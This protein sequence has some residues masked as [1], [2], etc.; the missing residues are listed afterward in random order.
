LSKVTRRDLIKA[1]A[2]AGVALAASP[3]LLNVAA[4]RPEV[5]STNGIASYNLQQQI[6]SS[7]APK[8]SG[9]GSV[10][11][12]LKDGKLVGYRGMQRFEVSDTDLIARISQKFV[13]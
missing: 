1:F 7:S 13:E 4:A 3:V 8:G 10:V 9:S 11:L 5:S 2:G 12:H 6:S